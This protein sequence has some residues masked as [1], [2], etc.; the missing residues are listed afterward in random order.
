VITPA[1]GF[2]TTLHEQLRG[3]VGAPV[4]ALA[5]NLLEDIVGYA[6]VEHVATFVEPTNITLVIIPAG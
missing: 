3:L 5:T 6:T 4:F 1:P 2:H